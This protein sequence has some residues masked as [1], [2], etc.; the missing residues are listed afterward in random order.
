M[1]DAADVP[2]LQQHAPARRMHG[3][4]NLK[5]SRDLSFDLVPGVSG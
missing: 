3:A 5:P 1:R 4:D 2:E